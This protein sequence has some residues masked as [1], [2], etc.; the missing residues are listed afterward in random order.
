MT[1]G[2]AIPMDVRIKEV[3]TQKELKAFVGFQYK[4][5][6][7]HPYW[8][9]PLFL[10]EV[11]TLRWDKN[12]AFEH[13]KARYWLAYRDGQIVGRIAAILNQPHIEKWGERYMRFG[14][15]DFIDDPAVSAALFEKVETWA[16]EQS[17]TAVHGPLGFTDMD[18]EG[19]LVEGFD[20]L[21][22]LV[23]IYNYP[24]YP[25]HLENL[26]YGKDTDWVEYE[27]QVPAEP[28][29]RVAKLS[30]LLL[31]RYNLHMLDV[32]NKKEMLL[33]A[34]QLFDLLQ[35]AYVN[36]YGFVPMTEAQ[37]QV[38]IDQYFGFIKPDFVPIVLDENDRM[39]AFG[40]TMPSLSHALQKSQGRLF[41]F[42]FIHLLWALRKNDRADLYLVA[43]RPEYQ[44][45]GVNAI[46]IDKMTRV[47]N[48]L[49]VTQVESNPELEDNLLV[50][51]Q[52][53]HFESR[54]HKRRRCYIKHLI[55]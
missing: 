20:E 35:E 49:G 45:R 4:L 23:G 29:E 19:M 9:P 28:D 1:A 31:K 44:G 32:K 55:P 22:T 51:G 12:P 47:F 36:L 18:P 17:L 10:D 34:G 13:S 27:L 53:K 54:Q 33:Y 48:R 41:P 40:I 30:K 16:R 2:K 38:Y 25:V 7:K 26:G 11:N 5:Y 39:V 3:S 43:V 15:V 46:L 52:W 24:Y 37:V 14:W 50:Q 6:R 21:G 42:G 8:V